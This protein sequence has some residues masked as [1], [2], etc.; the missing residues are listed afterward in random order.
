M[1]DAGTLPFGAHPHCANWFGSDSRRN[2]PGASSLERAVPLSRT[3]CRTPER[4]HR[5]VWLPPAGRHR[6]K[7]IRLAIQ[8]RSDKR[9]VCLLER[10]PRLR[11]DE[12]GRSSC[13]SSP[14]ARATP[15]NYDVTDSVRC[16]PFFL[17]TDSATRQ[18]GTECRLLHAERS[19]G[20][21]P[22]GIC[23]PGVIGAAGGGRS[24][25]TG[26]H[27]RRAARR[28]LRAMLFLYSRRRSR[29]S[30]CCL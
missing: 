1:I 11:E 17:G 25:S 13:L 22:V 2:A 8:P 18:R 26:I 7:Y 4:R 9:C 20:R 15:V 10:P 3:T 24:G 30:E 19:A 14:A 16:R 6:I 21:R 29:Y 28:Y 5:Q 12:P 23:L 27:G